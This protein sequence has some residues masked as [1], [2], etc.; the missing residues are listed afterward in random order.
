MLNPGVFYS[1]GNYII[2][3]AS[4]SERP[5]P[6]STTLQDYEQ[7]TPANV[8]AGPFLKKLLN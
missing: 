2:A 4:T 3:V 6:D 5:S 1:E 8:D 7:C